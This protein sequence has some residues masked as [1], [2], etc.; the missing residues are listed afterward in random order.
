MKNLKVLVAMLLA[1]VVVLS[2]TAC[3]GRELEVR[4]Y[5]AQPWYY[6][7][8]DLGESKSDIKASKLPSDIKELA[9]EIYT[10]VS[11]SYGIEKELPKIALI[12]END[13]RKILG[14]SEDIPVYGSYVPSSKTVYL[15]K[16]FS[17]KDAVTLA[18]EFL[19][20][21]SDNG[22]NRGL[23]YYKYNKGFGKY[24]S[25]GV[26]NYLA[27]LLYPEEVP[28]NYEFET[29]IAEQL[30][31][32]VGKDVL[33][34]AYFNSDV[35]ALRESVNNL[36]LDYYH[37]EDIEG[38][39]LDIFDMFCGQVD[40]YSNAFIYCDKE[41][42][43]FKMAMAMIDSLE[44]EVLFM[45]KVIGKNEE[46]LK[47]LKEYMVQVDSVLPYTHLKELSKSFKPEK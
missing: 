21:L 28:Q 9:V 19:H 27:F 45:G 22:S 18:H 46:Q 10:K 42:N 24:L 13:L 40:M 7:I 5:Q 36:L 8:P 6:E 33:E 31:V 1:F 4:Y 39:L 16:S 3:G 11:E 14:A 30:A 23:I 35:S 17:E 37:S 34:K 25:E 43:L 2:C 26:T 15:T 41:V 20:Y 38:M 47:I 32:C 29:H 44:E 12:E